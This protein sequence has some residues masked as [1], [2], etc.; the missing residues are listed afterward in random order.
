MARADRLAIAGIVVVLGVQTFAPGLSWSPYYQV[1][2]SDI[3]GQPHIA[4]NGIPHQTMLPLSVLSETLYNLPYEFV[5]RS[6]PSGF[7]SLARDREMMS[8]WPWRM[9]PRR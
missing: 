7:S 3:E 9:A 6:E 4:V 8:H 1:G 2:V 5:L